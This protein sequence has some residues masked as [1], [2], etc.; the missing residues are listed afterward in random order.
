MLYLVPDARKIAFVL[1]IK[2]SSYSLKTSRKRRE[3]NIF[4]LYPRDVDYSCFK[5]ATALTTVL[6]TQLYMRSL[7]SLN[8]V[9]LFTKARVPTD[10][11]ALELMNSHP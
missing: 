6:E 3:E 1:K 4:R 9:S 8:I 7:K 2:S 10:D 5:F 11:F